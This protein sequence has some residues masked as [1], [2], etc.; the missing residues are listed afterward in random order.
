MDKTNQLAF[1]FSG[2][3]SY[4]DSTGILNTPELANHMLTMLDDERLAI[5]EE[6]KEE[7]KRSIRILLPV[8]LVK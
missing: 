3:C 4:L 7:L 2:L 8:R 1:L 6:D 5:P